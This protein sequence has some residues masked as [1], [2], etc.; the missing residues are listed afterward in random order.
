M[1][2][3][4]TAAMNN[5][6]RLASSLSDVFSQND[7]SQIS[8]KSDF[9][10]LYS[11]RDPSY[12]LSEF[13]QFTSV[14]IARSNQTTLSFFMQNDLGN[15]NL[16]DVSVKTSYG[17]QLIVNGGFDNNAYKWQGLDYVTQCYSG[18]SYSY[19]AK[20]K[21]TLNSTVSQ[22]FNTTP[23]DV[24]NISFKLYW[25]GSGPGIFTKVTIYP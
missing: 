15:T 16:D 13:F 23:G 8:S 14:Y 9:T 11:F 24:L 10:I 22:T 19:C 20:S 21:N 2:D 4:L 25:S 6:E 17:S 1:I 5:A 3:P 12:G 18:Y 7:L